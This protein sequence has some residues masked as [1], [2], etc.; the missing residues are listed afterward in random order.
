MDVN[1]VYNM[2]RGMETL[3]TVLRLN[4]ASC[5]A[6]GFLFAAWPESV[7]QFLGTTP[8]SLVRGIGVL[9][10]GQGLYLLLSSWRA[11]IWPVEII[12]F[13]AGD[14]AWFIVSIALLSGELFITTVQG[15]AVALLVA[16]VVLTLGLVQLWTYAEASER[17]GTIS[18]TEAGLTINDLIPRNYTR[19]GAIVASWLA[20]KTWIKIW[21]FALNGIFIAAVMF[22]PEPAAKLTL[23]AYVASGPILAAMMIWQRGLTRALG[24]A[25]LVPW[26]PLSAY[27]IVRLTSD[28]A[29]PQIVRS[30]APQLFGYVLTLLLVMSA[31][32]AI[33]LYDLWRWHKGQRFR[34]GSPA[35]AEA[36]A[37]SRTPFLPV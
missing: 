6:F 2:V 13:S 16:C 22:L 26:L 14:I 27:L 12:Y 3:R 5:L 9:L 30:A 35:A 20:I 28:M 19:F 34:L 7:V 11:G 31:C 33:D 25:H 24:L 36:K 10:V 23:A 21:L 29:G 8:A 18:K 15:K 32:L 17:G 4:A 37:S 1:L